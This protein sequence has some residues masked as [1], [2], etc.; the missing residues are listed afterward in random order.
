M[1]TKKK[2]AAPVMLVACLIGVGIMAVCCIG[3]VCWGLDA[4]AGAETE[5]TAGTY[6]GM[7]AV[8][9]GFSLFFVW[10]MNSICCL[11]WV[12]DGILYRR[13]LLFR[14]C[15][16]CSVSDIQ[17][18]ESITTPRGGSWIFIVDSQ[19]GVFEPGM[20]KSYICLENT[21]TNRR[22]IATF[23]G[24]MIRTRQHPYSRR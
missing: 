8:S 19:P 21:E 10:G 18:L 12:E 17:R 15:R 1:N 22:F 14:Y 11:V 9:G 2:I 13:G 6:F 5:S 4:L 24:R 23:C 7:A 16:S 20:R 3:T